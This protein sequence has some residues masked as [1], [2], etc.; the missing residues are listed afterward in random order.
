MT[1]PVGLA[2]VIVAAGAGRRLGG[3]AKALLPHRGASYLAAI[4][5]T[6][7][8][9]GLVDAVVVVGEPF[10]AEVAAHARQLALRVRV[11]PAPERGMASSVA[12]GFAGLAGGPA[13]AAWLWPVDHPAVTADTLRRVIAAFAAPEAVAEAVPG[14]VPGAV[15]AAGIEVARPCFQGRGGHPPLIARSLWPRLAA[16][17]AEPDGARGVVRAARRIDVEVDDPGVVQDI[18]T[19]ADLADLADLGDLGGLG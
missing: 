9:V 12:L 6:A 7:R 14:A 17:A 2:A 5:A 4:A 8:A 18:D 1:A 16:C 13:A 19:A 3:V 10:A 11:N 15:P